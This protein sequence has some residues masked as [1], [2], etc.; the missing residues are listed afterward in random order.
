M[1]IAVIGTGR[2]GG[3]LGTGWLRAGHDVVFGSREPQSAEAKQLLKAGSKGTSA[4]PQQAAATAAVVALA[5]PW[6]SVADVLND[7]RSEIS[8]KVLI[9]CT[10]PAKEWPGMDRSGGSGGE[11]IAK[12]TPDAR[13]VKAF[14]TTGFE[15]MQNRISGTMPRPCSMQVTTKKRRKWSVSWHQTWVSTQ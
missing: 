11:H 3:A 12:W 4:L 1:K 5:V 13:V 7:I 14:N 10:N 2:V 6:K 9:D 8:G 15:N